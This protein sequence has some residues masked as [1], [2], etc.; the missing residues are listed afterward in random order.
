MPPALVK[1]TNVWINIQ[2]SVALKETDV[3]AV[4]LG[5]WIHCIVFVS[6]VN[7]MLLP[8]DVSPLQ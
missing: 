5:V 8:P 6:P 7:V 3:N 4:N 2:G 1:Q